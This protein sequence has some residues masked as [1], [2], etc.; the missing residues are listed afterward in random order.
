M[1]TGSAQQHTHTSDVGVYTC[2]VHLTFRLVEEKA[3]MAVESDQ[4]LELLL[5]ALS[6]GQDDCL[7]SLDT[8]VNVSETPETEASPRMRR[9]LM[10]L[11]NSLD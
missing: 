4:L 7:E 11:R 1:K 2:E 6:C 3:A 5:E 10:R 9:Q 8:Q